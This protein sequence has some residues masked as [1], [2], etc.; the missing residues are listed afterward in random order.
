MYPIANLWGL[1][2]STYISE[3]IMYIEVNDHRVDEAKI[4][5][6][7]LVQFSLSLTDFQNFRPNF[8]NDGRAFECT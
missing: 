1:N 3:E 8:W 7:K 5:G 6:M 4:T 2:N